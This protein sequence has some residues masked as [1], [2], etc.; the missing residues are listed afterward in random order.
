MTT[1]GRVRGTGGRHGETQG[2]AADGQHSPSPRLSS[3][4]RASAGT[5]PAAFTL[6]LSVLRELSLV[7]AAEQRP[8]T[9]VGVGR[10]QP[11]VGHALELLP[12]WDELT[13]HVSSGEKS[14]ANIRTTAETLRRVLT[15]HLQEA[16]GA[17]RPGSHAG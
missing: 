7:T 13:R 1:I 17:L 9:S 6:V 10:A 4:E 16:A 14:L 3:T 2:P 8:G 11:A 5:D 15:G 12:R